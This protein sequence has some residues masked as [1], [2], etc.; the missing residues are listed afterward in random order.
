VL[1]KTM[2]RNKVLGGLL[3]AFTNV[4]FRGNPSGVILGSNLSMDM[5]KGIA[6][7]INQPETAFIAPQTEKNVFDIRWLTPTGHEIELCGHGTLCAAHFLQLHGQITSKRIQF[8][9]QFGATLFADFQES[10]F[11]QLQFPSTPPVPLN[12]AQLT[13]EMISALGLQNSKVLYFGKSIYDYVIEVEDE[14]TVRKL[15]PNLA[16]LSKFDEVRGF[17]ITAQSQTDDF[18]FISR[19]FAPAVGIPEDPVTGSAHC[20]LAPYWRYHIGKDEMRGYQASSRGGLVLCTYSSGSENVFLRGQ[21]TPI[22]NFDFEEW[23]TK[24]SLP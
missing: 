16:A 11:I 19:F 17:I 4:P 5:M 23:S 21:V 3:N 14:N 24:L 7:E 8:N 15:D 9:T 20:S 22:W 2:K 12:I 18:D 6:M 1:C 10:G 13:P